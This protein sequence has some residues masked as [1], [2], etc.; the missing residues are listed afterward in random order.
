MGGSIRMRQLMGLALLL[1]LSMS[2][3]GLSQGPYITAA[4]P[5]NRGMG[6][7]AVAAPIDA[8]GATY[9]NPATITGLARSETAFSLDLL[10]PNHQISSS[11]GS[12]SGSTSADEGAFPIPNIGWVHHTEV[13]GLT[14][15]LGI[16][17]VA[18]FGTN[19][20]VDP[21]NPVLAPTGFGGFGQ[22]NSNAIFMQ[23]APVVSWAVHDRLSIAVGPTITTGRLSL[24][25]FIFGAANGDGTY[26]PAQGGRYQWGG[27]FQVGA[28]YIHNTNWRFGASFKSPTWMEDFEWNSTDE[29]GF[30]REL[31]WDIDLPMILSVGTSYD[32]FEN[33]LV[34]LDLRYF[35]YGNTAGFGDPAVFDATG[36]LGGLDYSSIMAMAIGAQRQIGQRTAVRMGY[37]FN[38]SPIRNA[39]AIVNLA[40]PLM[41]Q[42]VLN[43]GGS[44]DLNEDLACHVGYSYFFDNPRTGPI[45]LPGV[46][47]IQGTQVTN[48]L[49]AHVLSFGL[50]VRR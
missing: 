16:H 18:G 11:I 32:G 23:I 8:L 26:A 49:D 28:Y 29:N 4:G 1:A 37:T 33:W 36:A 50:T 5:V 27:G 7:A 21:T 13:D 45:V 38:Q 43:A 9:W 42:H 47:P 35:D 10:F 24:E 12:F 44:L 6:G 14:L 2:S 17:S 22:I 48:S 15:G 31:R 34:A 30:P 40:A 46:G 20:P 3:Q 41:Y 19:M 25:P 39:E